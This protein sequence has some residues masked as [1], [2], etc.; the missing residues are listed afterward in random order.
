MLSKTENIRSVAAPIFDADGNVRYA[1][2]IIGMFR[3]LE[4]DRFEKA[5]QV[6]RE[7][8]DKISKEL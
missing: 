3:Q 2:G 8:A 1:V 7:T 4:A 5:G 6:V